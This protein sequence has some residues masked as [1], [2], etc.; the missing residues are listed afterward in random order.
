MHISLLTHYYKRVFNS[1]LY[2]A[3]WEYTWYE[4]SQIMT[5]QT[6]CYNSVYCTVC[7]VV[8]GTLLKMA[9]VFVITLTEPSRSSS[10]W[11]R[12]KPFFKVH[13]WL[14]SL[15]YFRDVSASY[16]FIGIFFVQLKYTE[17]Y[18]VLPARPATH[19]GLCF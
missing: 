4:S 5:V 19:G 12:T 6:S 17:G 8:F 3:L 13:A 7:V 18:R 9:D 11:D 16:V 2:T 14:L 10:L 1:S 15:F